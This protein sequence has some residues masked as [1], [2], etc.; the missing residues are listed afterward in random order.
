MT[1]Y[2]TQRLHNDIKRNAQVQM[3]LYLCS[4]SDSRRIKV[5]MIVRI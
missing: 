1:A 5:I 2:N 4:I 3:K